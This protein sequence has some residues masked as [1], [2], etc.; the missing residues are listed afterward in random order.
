MAVAEYKPANDKSALK[1][2]TPLS[3]MTNSSPREYV[4]NSPST[5]KALP[6]PLSHENVAMVEYDPA[7]PPVVAVVACGQAWLNEEE[8]ERE[9]GQLGECWQRWETITTIAMI[10]TILMMT[11]RK[12]EIK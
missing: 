7:A 8:K 12:K 10:V 3:Y 9:G 4:P 2:N 11:E 1:E 5:A 6:K